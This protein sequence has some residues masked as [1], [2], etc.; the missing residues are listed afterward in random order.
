MGKGTLVSEL[1]K[2]YSNIYKMNFSNSKKT[3]SK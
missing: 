1:R 3:E 2:K